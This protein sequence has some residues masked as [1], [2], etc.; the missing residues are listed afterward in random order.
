M[1][2]RSSDAYM[3]DALADSRLI[4]IP[5][6][7]LKN[8]LADVGGIDI[9]EK[10]L[11]TASTKFALVNIAEK[12]HIKLDLLLDEI[13]PYEP[14]APIGWHIRPIRGSSPKRGRTPKKA[15]PVKSPEK[16]A[17]AN[18]PERSTSPSKK[19]IFASIMDTAASL[20]PISPPKATATPVAMEAAAAGSKAPVGVT[21]DVD[22]ELEERRRAFSASTIQGT[23][24]YNTMKRQRT[25]ARA[26]AIEEENRKHAA[27]VIQRRGQDYASMKREAAQALAAA[28]RRS[29]E[30]CRRTPEYSECLPA[31]QN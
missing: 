23:Y 4:K 12:H 26:L 24:R 18:S 29:V 20:L 19:S 17:T 11:F 3:N 13:G 8:Y 21:F 10:E 5:Y 15:T 22:P 31:T 25:Q 2:A 16:A 9:P 27:L 30:V 6:I 28:N 1:S 14:P 7:R